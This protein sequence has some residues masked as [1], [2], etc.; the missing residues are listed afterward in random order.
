MAGSL[1][2]HRAGINAFA[3]GAAIV[4]PP[5]SDSFPGPSV[6]GSKW[7]TLAGTTSIVGGRLRTAPPS[8][9]ADTSAIFNLTQYRV[10][11]QIP[12][13]PTDAAGTM[14]TR[15]WVADNAYSNIIQ[16][17]V[18]GN[19]K[20]LWSQG[21]GITPA[22]VA[23]YNA[24]NHQWVGLQVVGGNLLFQAAPDGV[25]WTTLRAVAAPAW[26]TANPVRVM[27]G[28]FETGATQAAGQYAE[29]DNFNN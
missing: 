1:A 12:T 9:E 14:K 16:Y 4:P 22:T 15:F 17:D 11:I 20:I 6:D 5:I 3:R 28:C 26:I 23:S 7:T 21:N 24:T 2:L 25:T 13:L 29:Y 8:G 18:E 19:P 10:Y 27:L